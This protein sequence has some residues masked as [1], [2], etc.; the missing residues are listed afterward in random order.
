MRNRVN[1][2]KTSVLVLLNITYVVRTMHCGWGAAAEPPPIPAK[3]CRGL[4]YKRCTSASWPAKQVLISLRI[5]EAGPD[6]PGQGLQHRPKGRR[7]A[8]GGHRGGRGRRRGT[9]A[10]WRATGRAPDYEAWVLAACRRPD[11]RRP[12]GGA[13]ADG[14]VRPRTPGRPRA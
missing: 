11:P 13:K 14:G 3:H 9:R 2:V 5:P 8:A 1:T 4:A 10:P 6:R 12:V 7:P